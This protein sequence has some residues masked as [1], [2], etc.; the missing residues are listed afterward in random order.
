MK[1]RRTRLTAFTLVELL[2]VIGIIAVL[3]A[4]LLPALNRAREQ[5]RAAK[6]LSNLRQLTIATLSYCNNSKGMFPGQGSKGMT[7]TDWI[8]WGDAPQ[9]NDPTQATW[10]D[11][12]ALQPYIGAT[13]DVLKT[14]LRCESDDVNAR[15]RM[16]EPT[17][18]RYSY[19]LN[20]LLTRPDQFRGLPYGYAGPSGKPIKIGQVR[21]ASNKVMFVEEDSKTIDDGIWKPFLIDTTTNPPTYFNGGF[22]PG[23]S[24]TQIS[25]TNPNAAPNQIADRHSVAKDRYAAD[26][27]GNVS[28]CDGHAEFFS[29]VDIGKQEFHDPFYR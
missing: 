19:S 14:L 10:I 12:S 6:C 11:N 13:G 5:A 17:V 26:G 9:E 2:V 16:T 7:K 15:A 24:P 22:A 27:R 29:R 4:M 1:S 21:N 8:A 25:P 23:A 3:I 20:Q 28:F 18:Y